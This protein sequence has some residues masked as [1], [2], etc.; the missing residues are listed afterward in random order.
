MMIFV[1]QELEH[2][3]DTGLDLDGFA[4]L[5]IRYTK[6]GAVS[7]TNLTAT[8]VGGTRKIVHVLT[9]TELDTPGLWKANAY[10]TYGSGK[11]IPCETVEFQVY[12]LGDSP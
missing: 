5:Q 6:P 9:T 4:T 1:G 11:V 10:V 3:L 2:E 7:T 12:N 8:R